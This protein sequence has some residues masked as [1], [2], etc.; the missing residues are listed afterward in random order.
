[1]EI[2]DLK[3]V[4][5]CQI[6]FKKQGDSGRSIPPTAVLESTVPSGLG[7]VDKSMASPVFLIQPDKRLHSVPQAPN[8]TSHL[9]FTAELHPHGGSVLR[10]TSGGIPV[11]QRTFPVMI[12]G[13]LAIALFSW[14]GT[15]EGPS[16]P[17]VRLYPDKT[18]IRP[19]DTVVWTIEVLDESIL[20]LTVSPEFNNDKYRESTVRLDTA[21]IQ[22]EYTYETANFYMPY[23]Q[24]DNYRGFREKVYSDVLVSV[25]PDL[26]TRQGIVL[27]LPSPEGSSTCSYVK[28]M[29]IHTFDYT[30]FG[31]AAGEQFI[32][33]ELDRI[34][35]LGCNAISFS[36]QWFIDDLNSSVSEPIYGDAWPACW[37]GTLPVDALIKLSNWTHERGMRVLLRSGLWLKEDHSGVQKMAWQPADR[38][39]Y[40][41]LQEQQK[42]AYA[43]L[44][45][46]LGV[47][48][49]CLD[50]ENDFFTQAEEVSA[51]ITAVREVYDGLVTNSATRVL[52]HLACPYV[53]ELDLLCW[54]DYFFFT[55]NVGSEL[56][57]GQLVSLFRLHYEKDIAYVLERF[58]KP[59]MVFETGVNIADT[60]QAT[61]E[62]QYTAYVRAF[63]SL[64]VAGFPLCG[65]A[66]WIWNLTD[67]QR[68]PHAMR[69]Q[70]AES[71]LR[72]YLTDVIA[73]TYVARFAGISQ[74]APAVGRTL[75]TYENGL[76]PYDTWWQGADVEAQIVSASP[77]S[78]ECLQVDLVPTGSANYRLGY[79]WN[80]PARPMNWSEFASVNFWVRASGESWGL[81]VNLFDADGDDYCTLWWIETKPFLAESVPETGGWH[82]VTIP[83]SLFS[84][85][86]WDTGGNGA[87]DWAHVTRWGIG[88]FYAD[89]VQQTFWVDDVYLSRQSSPDPSSAG[90]ADTSQGV[91]A[92]PDSDGDGVPDDEDYCPDWPGN[93]ATNGC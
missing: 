67:P 9:R 10:C 87:M 22:V 89:A 34:K 30:L 42:V 93:P 25:I 43:G 44:C 31:T 50:C 72:E 12:V 41:A 21:S 28:A 51:I 91:E 37:V 49:Y 18:E 77:R 5:R 70:T 26:E 83:F 32:Q 52:E 14:I 58:E 71:I 61:V 16:S 63:A 11:R 90:S 46:A 82:L 60:P 47:E 85:P 59:G 55:Q 54:S 33:S 53:D 19:G 27:A 86:S 64:Q 84:K 48:V 75:E 7:Y 69:G 1:V 13:I 36:S 38:G 57:E 88:L 40:F 2:A 73:D 78:G 39:L 92:L 35:G 29:T 80:A 24:A 68:E 4:F 65:H 81:R 20:P 45:E 76:P 8:F 23:I 56:T 79:V 17:K 66:W 3:G 62:L 6:C 15:A 74:L